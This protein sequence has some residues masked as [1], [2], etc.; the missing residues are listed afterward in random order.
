MKG[1]NCQANQVTSRKYL[2]AFNSPPSPPSISFCAQ[3]DDSVE[4]LQSE[5]VTQL[6]DDS[7]KSQISD[8]CGKGFHLP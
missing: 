5:E 1:V 2:R 3:D 8:R 7:E 4:R 6:D